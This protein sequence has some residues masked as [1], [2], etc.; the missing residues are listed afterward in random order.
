MYQMVVDLEDDCCH[1]VD[2]N[3]HVCQ[4]QVVKACQCHSNPELQ[5]QVILRHV[6]L[7]KIPKMSFATNLL[8]GYSQ[9]CDIYMDLCVRL[10][11]SFGQSVT[12]QAKVHN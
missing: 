1:Q 10:G 8:K 6:E 12:K 4:V 9:G 7:C 5:L 3:C 2:C 11:S